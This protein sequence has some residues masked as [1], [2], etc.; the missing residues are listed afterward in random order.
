MATSYDVCVYIVNDHCVISFGDRP[1]QTL[2]IP[3]GDRMETAQSSCSHCVI[4]ATSTQ[5]SHGA[6]AMSLQVPYD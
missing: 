3:C 2:Q 5:I 6:C 4:F 1:G